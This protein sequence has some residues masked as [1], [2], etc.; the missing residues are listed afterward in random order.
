MQEDLT[1]KTHVFADV[2]VTLDRSAAAACV[3][4]EL[5]TELQRRLS[6]FASST[7]AEL[8]GLKHA[9]TT[10][11]KLARR[12]PDVLIAV[13]RPP[14]FPFYLWIFST[15]WHACSRYEGQFCVARGTY[16]S[17]RRRCTELQ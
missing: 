16:T 8:V 6:Y 9:W 15:L 4:P 14:S 17:P 12:H 3:A 5:R 10:V 7:L 13:V 11:V 2:S 1:G